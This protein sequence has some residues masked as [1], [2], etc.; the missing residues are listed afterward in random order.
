MNYYQDNSDNRNSDFQG[1]A[2]KQRA[3]PTASKI[4]GIVSI[5]LGMF[6]VTACCLGYLSIPI[7]ALGILF[8]ILSRRLGEKLHTSGF[9]GLILSLIGLVLG[10]V[11]F[12]FTIYIT[13]TDPQFWKYTEEV[14][15]QYKETYEEIYG[16]ELEEYTDITF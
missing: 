4:C 9:T 2:E 5:I 3:L 1:Y 15:E 14:F 11:M 7:G 6:S 12:V 8:A 13:I 10:I 16:I